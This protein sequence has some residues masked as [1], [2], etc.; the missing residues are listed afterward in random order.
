MKRFLLLILVIVLLAFVSCNA[1]VEDAAANPNE[2]GAF[3]IGSTRFATLQ[4]AVNSL[5]SGA[6]DVSTDY[7]I[8]LTRD[9]TDGGAIIS[10]VPAQM[11][12]DFGSYT[13]TL[14]NSSVG[15]IVEDSNS[16]VEFSGGTV[17]AGS[18][19][20]TTILITA[21]GDTTISGTK[22]DAT[23]APEMDAIEAGKGN[24]SIT[25]TTEIKTSEGKKAI[26]AKETA[27]VDVIS[28]D[29]KITGGLELSGKAE[30]NL[31]K[32]SITITDI[33][34]A[35]DSQTTLT[36][37]ES[38]VIT[39]EIKDETAKQKLEEQVAAIHVHTYPDQWTVRTAATT[40]KAGLEYKACTGCGHEITQEIPKIEETGNP[41][42]DNPGTDNP[43]TGNPFVGTWSASSNTLQVVN[44]IPL[45]ID[46]VD[47]IGHVVFSE[48]RFQLFGDIAISDPVPARNHLI[49]ILT[50]TDT[51]TNNFDYS[52]TEA[53]INTMSI[54]EIRSALARLYMETPTLPYI[55][56][57]GEYSI[58]DEC[59]AI[60]KTKEEDYIFGLSFSI[61]ENGKLRG[62][63]FYAEE[64]SEVVFDD[65]EIVFFDKEDVSCEFEKGV[66]FDYWSCPVHMYWDDIPESVLAGFEQ[67]QIDESH[68]MYTCSECGSSHVYVKNGNY[69]PQ[70]E[71]EPVS[72]NPFVGSWSTEAEPVGLDFQG[73]PDDAYSGITVKGVVIFTDSQ[74]QT[75]E[76][77]ELKDEEALRD[78]AATYFN[79][80]SESW[81]TNDLLNYLHENKNLYVAPFG[82]GEL[83]GYFEPQQYTYD[84][85]Y[86]SFDDF[87]SEASILDGVLTCVV[88]GEEIIFTKDLIALSFT[89]NIYDPQPEE[90]VQDE[91]PFVGTWRVHDNSFPGYDGIYIF[92]ITSDKIQVGFDM[93]VT[94]VDEIRENYAEVFGDMYTA[95]QIAAMT[96]EELEANLYQYCLED[97][98]IEELPFAFMEPED[99]EI[100]NDSISGGVEDILGDFVITVDGSVMCLE[101][102]SI[103]AYPMY[104]QKEDVTD[105]IYNF[106]DLE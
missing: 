70:P 72:D 56:Y 83:S 78:I 86:V 102:Q 47:V 20:T 44:G 65:S 54:D 13:Y 46:G 61:E 36:K 1:N 37:T 11:R 30:V 45:S 73:L 39:V 28:A 92:I 34:I 26:V 85:E 21:F 5:K 90:L 2:T 101:F 106:L 59:N 95:D 76:L 104:G 32:G 52:L 29:V 87:D 103:H 89:D 24:V 67:Y 94:D 74:F 48:T 84:G 100:E 22:V 79:G 105:F 71:P 99:Y 27:K 42:T 17:V 3:R 60:Y 14:S 16:G 91:N 35:E 68:V 19:N 38:M 55:T 64:E 88:E 77:Y 15:I 82:F 23:A 40:E 7:T 12:I 43:G 62:I 49:G 57:D 4:A 41:G 8:V 96:D 51:Y 81:S 80:Y 31:E 10:N 75:A 58:D 9:V 93:E 33:R 98:G 66:P 69:N 6:K 18:G 25:G 53:D 63:P 50:K 97:L